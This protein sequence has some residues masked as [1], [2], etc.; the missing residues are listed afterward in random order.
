ME[1]VVTNGFAELSAIE[2]EEIDGGGSD[3]GQSI[4]YSVSYY[5]GKG[6]KKVAKAYKTYVYDPMYEFGASLA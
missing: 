2:M 4:A 1:M 3:P 5:I 6:A